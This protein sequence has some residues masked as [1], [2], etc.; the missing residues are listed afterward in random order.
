M[1]CCIHVCA[2]ACVCTREFYVQIA[3]STYG[4]LTSYTYRLVIY[5]VNPV[6]LLCRIRTYTLY[7]S[8]VVKSCKII[9]SDWP[10]TAVYHMVIGIRDKLD[11]RL[12][13][14]REVI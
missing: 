1:Q 8:R 3:V 14:L 13:T 5:T 12:L 10:N 7:N 11:V 2:R 9:A 6:Y 4:N